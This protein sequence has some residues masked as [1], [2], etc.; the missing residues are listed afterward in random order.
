MVTAPA[1]YEPYS[2][3]RR[4][5]AR[6]KVESMAALPRTHASAQILTAEG[7][8]YE[9]DSA[10]LLDGDCNTTAVTTSA[11]DVEKAVMVSLSQGYPPDYLVVCI[12]TAGEMPE[13]FRITWQKGIA[14]YIDIIN[15]SEMADGMADGRFVFEKPE[16]FEK[17][18]SVTVE[19]YADGGV[20]LNQLILSREAEDG[21][22]VTQ[23]EL[24][25]LEI[26]EKVDVTARSF[27]P[28]KLIAEFLLVDGLLSAPDLSGRKM[29]AEIE[30][31]GCFINVG[32]FYI[33]SLIK[34]SGGLK[35]RI[36]ASDIVAKIARYPTGLSVNI[37]TTVGQ[38]ISYGSG[39]V[40]GLEFVA[41]DY[42]LEAYV[43]PNMMKE[44]DSK[45]D[46]LLLMSQAARMSSI[47]TDRAG[48]V[49]ISCLHRK[50]TVSGS[51]PGEGI[52]SFVSDSM[53]PKYLFAEVFGENP[54]GEV[55]AYSGGYQL[56]SYAQ[57]LKNNFLTIQEANA[58]AQ[59]FLAALNLR[60][61]LVLKTRCDPTLE[62]G[63]RVKVFDRRG[64][65]VG[66]FFIAAQTMRLD[67]RGLSADMVLVG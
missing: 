63:D 6:L 22:T 53:G 54:Y 12:D 38:L 52:I 64:E 56:G 51:I 36:E 29:T 61:K 58:V 10:G 47:W 20:K 60:R 4:V 11:T 67:D 33:D 59:N 65:T 13:G 2:T 34:L 55:F 3:V 50:T 42:S 19:L 28:R 9:S 37:P 32:E 49:N 31:N 26:T 48:R 23:K 25:R 62:A 57:V 21:I 15:A 18:E 43:F 1:N 7:F 46:C 40:A 35:Y 24:C 66:E 41:D 30:I 8:T 5:G 27:Q 45:R 16:G 17:P 14:S 44:I 39:A